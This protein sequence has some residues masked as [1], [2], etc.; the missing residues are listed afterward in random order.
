MNMTNPQR[1]ALT[2]LALHSSI[3][4]WLSASEVASYLYEARATWSGA[5]RR[6]NSN[7]GAL[8]RKLVCAGFAHVRSNPLNP[9]QSEYKITSLGRNQLAKELK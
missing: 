6:Q 3:E 4:K 2:V 9:K 1:R 8:L 5:Y 7:A